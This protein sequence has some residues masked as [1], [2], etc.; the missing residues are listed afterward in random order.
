E[1]DQAIE[2]LAA[3][4]PEKSFSYGIHQR[5]LPARAQ[6]ANHGVLGGASTDRTEPVVAIADNELRP[7]PERRR[8]AQ[9]LRRPPLRRSGRDGNVDDASRVHVDDEEREDGTEPD[10]VGLKE[11]TGP[12]RMVSQ[13]CPPALS[14]TRRTGP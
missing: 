13:Q 12:H 14:A 2:A 5:A 8:I 6:A 4:P 3:D 9:L 7:L 11:I 1:D 10:V